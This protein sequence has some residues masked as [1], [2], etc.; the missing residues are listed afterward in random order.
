MNETAL[1]EREVEE[2][3]TP[4]SA[5]IRVWGDSLYVLSKGTLVVTFGAEGEVVYNIVQWGK[6]DYVSLQYHL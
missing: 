3:A 2:E 1:R 5:K 6:F 4:L